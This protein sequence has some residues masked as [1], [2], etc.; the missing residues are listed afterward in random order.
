[1]AG[2]RKKFGLRL[3]SLSLSSGSRA[4]RAFAVA[5]EVKGLDSFWMPEHLLPVFNYYA[6]LED[7][8]TLEPLESLAYVAGVTSRIELGTAVALAPFRHPLLWAK[9]AATLQHL[10]NGRLILGVGT[11]WA[12]EEFRAFGIPR[13]ERGARTDETVDV[14]LA[15]FNG[16]PFNHRGR[17]FHFENVVVNPPVPRPLL[18]GAGGAGISEYSRVG[19]PTLA[20]TVL[21]RLARLDGWLTRPTANA[22]QV[23]ADFDRIR[24]RAQAMGRDPTTITLAHINFCHLI[25]APREQALKEQERWFAKVLGTTVPFSRIRQMHW[26]GSLEDIADQVQDRLESGVD[27]VIVHPLSAD[28]DQV[29]LWADGVVSRLIPER[30]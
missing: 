13:S 17:V 27:H 28:S 12:E 23:A 24:E 29:R 26:T 20:D 1:M 10:S 14:L 18:W 15:A 7:D 22:D 16:Q 9:M 11:G 3:P 19:T 25:D 21:E 4:L 8:P 5:A 6:F 30:C 2:R